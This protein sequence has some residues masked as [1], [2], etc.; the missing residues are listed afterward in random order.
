MFL[1]IEN[2][3]GLLGW[4]ATLSII[5]YKYFTGFSFITTTVCIRCRKAAV[6]AGARIIGCMIIHRL[7]LLQSSIIYV[8]LCKNLIY[9][10][11]WLALSRVGRLSLLDTSSN[12]AGNQLRQERWV[13]SLFWVPTQSLSRGAGVRGN[14]SHLCCLF[15]VS[16]WNEFMNSHICH[17]LQI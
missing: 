8:E 5:K 2:C 3:L 4:L 1:Y 10:S 15:I 13:Y 12:K 6:S 7:S 9:F 14:A 17:L 11:F 16:H